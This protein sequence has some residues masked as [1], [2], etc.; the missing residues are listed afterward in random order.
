[1]AGPGGTSSA[2]AKVVVEP[3][4]FEDYFAFDHRNHPMQ[5]KTLT[6]TP[7]GSDNF[8]SV[9]IDDASEFPVDPTGGT[10]I[11]LG[12]DSTV[13]VDLAGNQ[14]WLYGQPYTQF[15]A[16][17]NGYLTF[18]AGDRDSS[19]RFYDHFDTPRISG[20]FDDLRVLASSTVSW[21]QLADKV[22]VTYEDV[23]EYGRANSINFQIEMYFDG[24]IRL[25]L[26]G[27]DASDGITGLSAGNG[28]PVGFV[29][30]D[31]DVYMAC[32]EPIT[33]CEG[34]FNADGVMDELDRAVFDAEFERIDCGQVEPCQADFDAD[35]DVDEDD[36]EVF[37]T[38]F[39]R[40]DCPI[41]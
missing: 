40:T 37:E 20:L 30:S 18:V 2:K 6:F 21:L 27:I 11:S 19:E 26:L 24:M 16:G 31:P 17:S 35:G 13:A 36:W 28:Q 22:V 33:V 12:D 29:E 7:N 10:S 14:V 1:M 25:T 4:E 39:G 8:Y 9:C 15:Y 34:D 5:N 38:D 41:Q 32:S 3:A 23:E